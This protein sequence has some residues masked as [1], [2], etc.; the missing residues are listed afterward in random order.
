MGWS[1]AGPSGE[2]DEDA[3]EGEEAAGDPGEDGGRAGDGQRVD[4]RR[5]GCRLEVWLAGRV[6]DVGAGL[7]VVGREVRLDGWVILVRAGRKVR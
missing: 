5:L 3:A 7:V 4:W 2:G 1:C 6:V